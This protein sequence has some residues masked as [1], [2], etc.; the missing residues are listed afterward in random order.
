VH[1]RIESDGLLI[2]VFGF[3]GQDRTELRTGIIGVGIHGEG[4]QGYQVDAI[5]LFQCGEIGVAQ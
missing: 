5:A 2:E 1:L 3:P 4:S